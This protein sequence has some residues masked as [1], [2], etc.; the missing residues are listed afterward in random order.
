MGRVKQNFRVCNQSC[1]F[2]K[3]NSIFSL[4][5]FQV[6]LDGLI[7]CFILTTNI[8]D[9][10]LPIQYRDLLIFR[11]AFGI[12][13]PDNAYTDFVLMLGKLLIYMCLLPRVVLESNIAFA[14]TYYYYSIGLLGVFSREKMFTLT[15]KNSR[16]S[17]FLQRGQ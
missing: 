2:Q 10:T 1:P 15:K 12:F 17:F 4:L 14:G 5:Y 7:V 9:T 8:L 13:I 16:S 6:I 3:N 11:F